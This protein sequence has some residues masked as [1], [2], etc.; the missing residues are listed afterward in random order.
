MFGPIYASIYV[1]YSPMRNGNEVI[2][3]TVLSF[4]SNGVAVV[5]DEGNALSVCEEYARKKHNLPRVFFDPSEIEVA[6]RSKFSKQVD[7]D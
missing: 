3:S 6:P 1:Q 5:K 2:G 4:D 7:K